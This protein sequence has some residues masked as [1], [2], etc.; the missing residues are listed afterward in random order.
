[1]LLIALALAQAPFDTNADFVALAK[2]H[3]RHEW[4]ADFQ[5]QEYCLRGQAAGM[6]QFKAA[7]DELGKPFESTLEKCTEEWT[8][9]RIPDWQMIGD[10]AAKQAEAFRRL[11]SSAPLKP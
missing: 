5:M 1:M 11:N 2:E 7:S 8:K 4:P 9:D 10:C 3:C 6:L